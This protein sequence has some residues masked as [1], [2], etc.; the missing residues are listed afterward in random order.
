MKIAID[1][2]PIIYR[3]GVSFYTTNLLAGLSRLKTENDLIVFG[4]SL[5]RQKELYRIIK[6]LSLADNFNSKI[7]PFPPLFFEFAW[8]RFHCLKLENFVGPVD[9]FHAS[10]WTHPPSKKSKVVTTVHD[11]AVLR[12]PQFF[13]PRILKNQ[14]LR[15]RWI[16]KEAD[17]VITVSKN[18]KRDIIKTFNIDPKKIFVIYESIPLEHKIEVKEKEVRKFL[19]KHKLKKFCLF[20]GTIEPR[21]NIQGVVKAFK[22]VN[23]GM[24]DLQLVIVGKPGWRQQGVKENFLDKNLTEDIKVLK[25]VTDKE[26]VYLYRRAQA[27]L[28][29]SFYE[30]F[31]LPV[32]EAMYH[33]CPVITS[34][35][36]SLP[37]IAGKGAILVDPY[38]TGE[39]A[40]ALKKIV[41][42]K[43]FSRLL[44]KRGVEN[45]KRFSWD[46]TA[47]K[48]LQVYQKIV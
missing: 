40:Q 47:Q 15:L 20:V 1:V 45:V 8:N 25:K 21:K 37:E 7:Y 33:H 23:S 39:I 12:Y 36:S 30:G 46:E 42:N 10:D 43:N 4:G 2:S 32:L 5:R 14:C 22:K 31:G 27:L 6:N 48:T 16:Q 35:V 41:N 19:Q 17:A 11:L 44:I 28:Y 34:K 26:L 18:T 13:P 38:Q 24:K 9:V 3:T 29:P